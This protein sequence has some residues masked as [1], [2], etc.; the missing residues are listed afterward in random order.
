MQVSKLSAAEVAAYYRARVPG[1]RPSGSELR[2]RCPIHNGKSDTSFSVNLAQGTWFCHSQCKFG[3]SVYDLEMKLAGHHDFKRAAKAVLEAIGRADAQPSLPAPTRGGRRDPHAGWKEVA[4]YVYHDAGGLPIY[5]VVRSERPGGSGGKPDKYFAQSSYANGEW[6][7]GA[8]AMRGVRRIPF[9]LPGLR[10]AIS[11]GRVVYVVEGEKA[12]EALMQL[13]LAA[14]TNSEGAGKWS[15]YRD[16]LNGEFA[17]ARVVILPDNDLPGCKHALNVASELLPVALSVKLLSLAELP[18]KGDVV[19]WL[20]TGGTKAE[21]ER[22]AAVSPE[23][24]RAAL[25]KLESAWLGK[26]ESPPPGAPSGGDLAEPP[27]LLEGDSNQIQWKLTEAGMAEHVVELY[28]ESIRFCVD[29]EEFAYFTP[30]K[31]LLATEAEHRVQ[32]CVNHEAERLHVAAWDWEQETIQKLALRH[33]RDCRKNRTVLAIQG[34]I[35]AQ[36]ALETKLTNFDAEPWLLNCANG[37]VDL[38]S[39]EVRALRSSDLI[40]KCLALPYDPAAKAPRWNRFLQ[41]VFDGDENLIDYLHKLLGYAVC[42]T[43]QHHILPILIGDGRNGKGVLFRAL[44]RVLEQYV[45][46][47]SPETLMVQRDAQRVRPELYLLRG[48]RIATVQ[49]THEG[50]PLDESLIK[51]LTGGDSLT[52]R[53]LHA[54]PVTFRPTHTLLVATNHRPK[55]QGRGRAIWSRL[56]LIPFDVCFE[57]REDRDL[58]RVLASEAPGILAWIVEGAA[59]HYEEGLETPKRMK[60]LIA[61]YRRDES[62]VDRFIEEN[63]MKDAAESETGGR[64][65]DAF[66][67]WAEKNDEPTLTAPAFAGELRRLGYEKS[68][69]NGNIVYRGL[70]LI[71]LE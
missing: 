69:Y 66:N 11:E 31:W 30:T 16:S 9:G 24:D 62:P 27:A 59:R 37:V 71:V 12:A 28:G 65:R 51:L 36:V 21:L 44:E 4:S 35:Q 50:A 41:E 22:L 26:Q 15:K 55:I 67:R 8:N 61:E 17:G 5:R 25:M 23:L 58:D 10:A 7:R 54:N 48:A 39:G 33:A 14:T 34:R 29:S 57:G 42:G 19:D 56:R 63:C 32:A 47:L 46:N 13:G 64:L 68:K 1:L 53:A 20:A 43:C 40:T 18:E 38:R 6:V 45:V 52:L 2:A 70:S 3:G 60:E 49:E